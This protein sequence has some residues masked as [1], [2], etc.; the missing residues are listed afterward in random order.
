M[1][2]KKPVRPAADAVRSMTEQAARIDKALKNV[3]N[4]EKAQRKRAQNAAQQ[5]YDD[6]VNT[7][8]EE[9]DV[10]HVNKARQGIRV[11][12]LRDAGIE[13][14]RQLS[15]LSFRQIC[16]IDGLGEQSAEKIQDTVKQI[17]DN[18]KKTLRIRIRMENPGDADDELIQILY[19]LL[20]GRPIREKCA[21]LYKKHHASVE[22]EI[23]LA[24]Q[25]GGAL[26]WLFK[27]RAK[28]TEISSAA[29]SLQ[30]RLQGEF[31]TKNG[32]EQW[33]ELEQVSL[34][35]CIHVHTQGAINFAWD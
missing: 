27:S 4:S 26:G 13:N 29:E 3:A 28:K 23:A 8:L 5:L 34:E 17:I 7:A 35:E 15:A 25:S 30:A 33:K 1:A 32:L 9:M 12:L 18:T 6:R 22:R 11:Q 16:D 19:A 21:R 14:I 10:E 24:Q 20:H 31:G 2:E